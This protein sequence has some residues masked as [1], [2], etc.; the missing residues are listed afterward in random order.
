MHPAPGCQDPSVTLTGWGYSKPG[1]GMSHE[2]ISSSPFPGLEYVR[3]SVS[4][5]GWWN[6]WSRQG[7]APS[8]ARAVTHGEGCGAPVRN[9]SEGMEHRG[10][11][12][13]STCQ[14]SQPSC[15]PAKCD[16]ESGGGK[17][18]KKNN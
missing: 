1:R 5:K 14:K 4:E 12:L 18:K 13:P 2:S 7:C 6:V 10:D 8:A 15:D 3:G 17:M 16:T 9:K 11:C